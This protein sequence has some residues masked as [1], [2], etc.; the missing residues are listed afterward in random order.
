VCTGTTLKRIRLGVTRAAEELSALVGRPVAEV[1]SDTR[2]SASGRDETIYLGT[3]AV[4][5]AGFEA[6]VVVFLDFDQELHAPRYRAAEQAMALLTRASRLVGGRRPG[7]RIL[8]QTRSPDHRVLDAAVGADPGRMVD[9]ERAIRAALG[10]P[11]DGAL[12]EVSGQGA[13]ELAASLMAA[14]PPVQVLGPRA[15]GHYLIR[16]DDPDRLASALGEVPR[17]TARVR[18]AVDPPRV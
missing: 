3:E 10:F 14:E 15:D 12:A 8:V 9:E 18:V 1:S 4:L 7:A 16:A 5:R 13:D 11:P 2:P 17:P 6:E